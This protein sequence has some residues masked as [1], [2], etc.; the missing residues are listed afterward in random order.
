MPVSVITLNSH[1]DG[2][3]SVLMVNSIYRFSECGLFLP[4]HFVKQISLNG[5]VFTSVPYNDTGFFVEKS[6]F[7]P[8]FAQCFHC[9]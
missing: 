5:F 3:M 4:V 2:V 9:N 6:T 7:F 8:I 1:S